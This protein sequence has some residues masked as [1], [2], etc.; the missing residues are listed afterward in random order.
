[1]IVVIDEAANAGLKVTRQEVVFQ[2]DAV[3]ER[4]MPALDLA[5][6]PRTV[7]AGVSGLTS[8]LLRSPLEVDEAEWSL[9]AS[10]L[11]QR[12]AVVPSDEYPR[13]TVR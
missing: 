2:Q 10:A 3:R 11:H 5:L 9:N 8:V 6:C 13:C 12:A 4:L 7:A 1:M